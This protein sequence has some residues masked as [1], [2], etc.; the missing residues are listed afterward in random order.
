M[1]QS[2][3]V[4]SYHIPR[5]S[6]VCLSVALLAASSSL[7]ACP[8]CNVTSS[9]ISEELEEAELSILA[10]ISEPA[11]PIDP[12]ASPDDIGPSSGT[13]KFEVV[14]FLHGAEKYPDLKELR[15]V[16]FGQYDPNQLFLINGVDVGLPP[17]DSTQVADWMTPLPLSERGVEYVK[18]LETLPKKGA[19]RLAFFQEYFEDEDPLLATDA[20]DEFARAAYSEVIA[21]SDRMDREQLLE[22]ISDAEVGPTH[23]RLY[24]T[25]LG[26]CGHK[27]DADQLESMIKY[28]FQQM[29]PALNALVSV[30]EVHGS[31]LGAPLASE[32]VRADVRRQQQCLDALIAAYLKLK[33]P[34]GLPLINEQFLANPD[35]EYTQI[36]ATIMALR[37]H[38]EE[39]DVIPREDLLKSIR[40]VLD[41]PEAAD[42]ILPDLTRWEDWEVL[43]RL[44]KMYK[45]ADK[46]SWIRDPV[47][48]YVVVAS[49]QPGD[50]GERAAK[51]LA[52][53][54]EID[55]QGVKRAK[56]YLSF[57]M[58]ARG[59]TDNQGVAS[60]PE[61]AEGASADAASQDSDNI[62]QVADQS[63]P[64]ENA[65]LAVPSNF[66][67][68]GAPLVA[69]LVLMG[70]Y[71]LLL[72]SGDVRAHS[73]DKPAADDGANI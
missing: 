65:A 16:Y 30:M 59:F 12:Y 54:E 69:C 60:R 48:S 32:L 19:D 70:V 36:Y 8:F 63:S 50:V 46:D 73:E 29:E 22:W 7:W 51:A 18:K 27:D 68:I 5:L 3:A 21:L 41:N 55:P 31:S 57:G 71:T 11:K 62:R 13:A 47:V 35:V 39:T 23:R 24:L 34:S 67:L 15:V 56:S 20:Y 14:E 72:R 52:E 10:R 17:A 44:V 42:L 53:F 9:T 58:F 28:N 2:S 49:E 61:P 38:G 45:E 64:P 25:M 6:I 1:S 33:G 66:A 4:L 40:L 37:F 26:V 43:D